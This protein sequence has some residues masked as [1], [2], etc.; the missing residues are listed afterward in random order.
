[1]LRT[2]GTGNGGYSMLRVGVVDKSEVENC[3]VRDVLD[4]LGDKWSVLSLLVLEDGTLRFMEIKRRIGDISQRVLT[5]TLRG[6]ERDGLVR[7][8]IYPEV[9][10]RVEYT[11]TELGRSLLGPIKTL[12]DWAATAHPQIRTARDT[13]DDKM[14]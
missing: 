4:R 6:L 2:F 5:Q 10:P 12:V 8:T 9:P 14:S 7:R 3:P 13:F 11:L 1:M